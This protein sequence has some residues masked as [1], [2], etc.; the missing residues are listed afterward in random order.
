M[1]SNFFLYNFFDDVDFDQSLFDF[2]GFKIFSF[3][4]SVEIFGFVFIL[5]AYLVGIISFLSLDSQFFEKN[6]KYVF[7]CNMLVLIIYLFTICSDFLLFFILYECLL[8]PSFLFVY[9]TSQ[10]KKGIQA[11]LYFLI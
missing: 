2:V 5:L 4:F 1:L 8:I 9:N 7:V 6:F 3:N 11:S 10:Y